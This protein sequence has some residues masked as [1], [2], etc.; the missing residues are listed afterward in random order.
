M[1]QSKPDDVVCHAPCSISPDLNHSAWRL[2]ASKHDMPQATAGAAPNKDAVGWLQA[3]KDQGD[4]PTALCL[5]GKKAL[6]RAS[7]CTSSIADVL[8]VTKF[9]VEDLVRQHAAVL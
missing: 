1:S 6:Q 5:A 2:R 7:R 8:S 4:Q 3:F 9:Q